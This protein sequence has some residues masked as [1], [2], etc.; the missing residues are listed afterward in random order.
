MQASFDHVELN[1]DAWITIRSHCKD[2]LGSEELKRYSEIYDER[3]DDENCQSN[4]ADLLKKFDPDDEF[5]SVYEGQYDIDD[6]YNEK[7]ELTCK[8]LIAYDQLKAFSLYLKD[9]P[10][11]LAA[12]HKFLVSIFPFM[13]A[14]FIAVVIILHHHSAGALQ[15]QGYCQQGAWA[16]IGAHGMGGIRV[17]RGGG[18]KRC[19]GGGGWGR[20]WHGSG[21]LG[22][23]VRS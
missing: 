21:G 22:G 12:Y 13:H 17:G 3:N 1:S 16:A 4:W 20:R 7:E 2:L 5:V 10:A 11:E 6:D 15:S 8:R 19:H 14:Y 9:K 18:G 23:W